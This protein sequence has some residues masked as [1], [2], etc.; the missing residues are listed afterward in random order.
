MCALPKPTEASAEGETARQW[1]QCMIQHRPRIHRT[2]YHSKEISE[3]RDCAGFPCCNEGFGALVVGSDS[4]TTLE[5]MDYRSDSI[6]ISL[7]KK[8]S[9]RILGT[10]GVVVEG[11]NLV[12]ISDSCFCCVTGCHINIS[13]LIPTAVTFPTT[14]VSLVQ[15]P[16]ACSCSFVC[17]LP[18]AAAE[19]VYLISYTKNCA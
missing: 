10:T 15:V 19:C 4:Q 14:V 9:T 17:T 18:V 12:R 8:M 7:R 1:N 3:S 5:K 6:T 13:K 2:D 11:F 16:W